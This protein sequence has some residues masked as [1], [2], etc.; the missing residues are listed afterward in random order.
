VQERSFRLLV[1]AVVV[2]LAAPAVA[3]SRADRR[4]RHAAARRL[5]AL[6]RAA[7]LTR[8]EQKRD[9]A[10]RWQ[11][12]IGSPLHPYS[13]S[14]RRSISVAYN[15]WVLRLWTRRAAQARRQA[16]RPPHRA[17]WLCIHRYEADWRDGDPPYYG[18]L[19]MDIAFQETYAPDL[20]RRKGTAEH[21]TPLEQMWV[22][23]RAFRRGRGFDPWAN[24]A[25]A[26]GLI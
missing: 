13:H 14:V 6:E 9:E 17:Q 1:L 8:V 20:V 18:G 5:E 15:M 23:E 24:T 21:W 4:A 12:L 10:W 22:A 16:L 7:V 25:R 2:A 26:C 11:R 19:Q 3:L